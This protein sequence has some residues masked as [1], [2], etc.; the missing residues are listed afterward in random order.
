MARF[1]GTGILLGTLFGSIF[2]VSATVWICLVGYKS[3]YVPYLPSY[4]FLKHLACFKQPQIN[5]RHW[6]LKM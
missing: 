6:V 4:V 5:Q 3:I 2:S 1:S